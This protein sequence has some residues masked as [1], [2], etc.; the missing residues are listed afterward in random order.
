M[1]QRY[2]L[3]L[4]ITKGSL[5][6]RMKLAGSVPSAR[7]ITTGSNDHLSKQE[8]RFKLRSFTK[9]RPSKVAPFMM[10]NR[11]FALKGSLCM[12]GESYLHRGHDIS[13][14]LFHLQRRQSDTRTKEHPHPYKKNG[15]F[16]H[17]LPLM[18]APFSKPTS[19]CFTAKKC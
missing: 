7:P 18:L 11:P 6:A 14:C 19:L 3:I 2:D 9:L 8:C 1:F 15:H 16:T 5:N 10:R 13:N 4:L 12:C 17:W